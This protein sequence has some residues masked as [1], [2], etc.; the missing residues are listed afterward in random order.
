MGVR[1]SCCEAPKEETSKVKKNIKK[2]LP[3]E[4]F[5]ISIPC[6]HTKILYLSAPITE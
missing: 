2:V 6:I 3:A 4:N 1:P 5:Q